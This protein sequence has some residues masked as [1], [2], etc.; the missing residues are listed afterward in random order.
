MHRDDQGR[1]HGERDRIEIFFE[2]I[3]NLI[4]QRRIDH[5]ARID[6]QQ[7]VAI[8]CHLGDAAHRDI[9]AAAADV[10]DEELPARPV[11]EILC[12]DARDDVGRTAGCVG[13]HHPHRPVRI[14]LR[15]R[16]ARHC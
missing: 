11:R 12:D 4:V 8:G 2:A 5:V 3:W 7:R 1:Q 14:G 6:H 16:N 13:N 9:A 15:A 10:L